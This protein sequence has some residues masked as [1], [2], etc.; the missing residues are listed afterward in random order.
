MSYKFSN[1][2]PIFLQIEEIIKKQIVSSQILPGEKLK[3]VRELSQEFK[4]NP[5]TIQNALKNL[6][7]A[8]L[9]YTDRT[10]GK[11]VSSDSSVILN[12]KLEQ[13]NLLTKTYLDKMKG[14]GLDEKQIIKFIKEN[15]NGWYIRI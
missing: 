8:G 12:S 5:N 6:E 9:I 1:E 10:N 14:L 2:K 13:I 4:V 3:S 11:F 7:D 15:L